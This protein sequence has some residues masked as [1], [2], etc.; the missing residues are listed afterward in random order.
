MLFALDTNILIYAAGI[1]DRD[2]AEKARLVQTGLGPDR[3]VIATQVVGELYHALVTRLKR[4]RTEAERACTMLSRAGFIKSA[5][6]STFIDALELASRHRLQFWDALI[7]CTA[8]E[9]GC[10]ALLSEDMQHGF[11]HR[12]TTVINP[13]S[14]PMHP[15]LADALRHPR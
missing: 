12:G 13:F 8:A 14:D 5:T 9:A 2:R 3:I 6:D 11:V 4:E 10:I 1:N 7:L 15:L